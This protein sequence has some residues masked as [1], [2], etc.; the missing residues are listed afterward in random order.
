[1][2]YNLP[3]SENDLMFDITRS[4]SQPINCALN[5]TKLPRL[6]DDQF[7]IILGSSPSSKDTNDRTKVCKFS[8]AHH[9]HLAA[10]QVPGHTQRK[11]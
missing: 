5:A 9:H 8:P 7:L 10:T 6:K 4:C 3:N 1:M 2:R 11:C